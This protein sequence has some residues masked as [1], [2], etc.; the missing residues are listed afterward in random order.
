MKCAKCGL[1]LPPGTRTCPR[2]G[3]VNEFAPV[4]RRATNPLVYVVSA[5]AVIGVI[6]L[7][8]YAVFA[9]KGEKSPSM[10]MWGS[11]A[12]S[13]TKSTALSGSSP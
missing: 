3:N 6:A 12:T 10:M 8:F 2:C 5:L 4:E 11:A 7:I 9:A 13:R 1:D